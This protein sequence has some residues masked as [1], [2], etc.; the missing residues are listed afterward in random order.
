[1]I[2]HKCD[3]T[4]AYYVPGKTGPRKRW[5][6]M[7]M[8]QRSKADR[9]ELGF[10]SSAANIQMT[11]WKAYKTRSPYMQNQD[12]HNPPRKSAKDTKHKIS[13]FLQIRK[14]V[15]FITWHSRNNHLIQQPVQ[16]TNIYL[17]VNISHATVRCVTITTCIEA[18]NHDN[19]YPC[20]KKDLW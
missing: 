4:M 10:F 5:Q 6:S 19:C 2:K 16:W 9:F 17:N 15:L 18:V 3:F 8:H 13:F 14:R 1:M 20:T 12:K 7:Y 11:E